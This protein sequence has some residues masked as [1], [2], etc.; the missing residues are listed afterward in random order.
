MPPLV[1]KFLVVI[2]LVVVQ[3]SV[4]IP[5]GVL[6]FPIQSIDHDKNP[7]DQHL[8]NCNDN[9]V[10]IKKKTDSK[11]IIC[12]MFRLIS[13]ADNVLDIYF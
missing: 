11:A 9:F 3:F 7:F 8:P 5:L 6:P 10:R 12:P 13:I 2:L 1:P 4:V